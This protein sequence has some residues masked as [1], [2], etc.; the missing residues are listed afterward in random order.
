VAFA[1]DSG[2]SILKPGNR[3]KSRLY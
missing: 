3:R 1:V 2:E